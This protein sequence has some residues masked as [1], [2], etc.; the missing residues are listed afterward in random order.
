MYSMLKI[1]LFGAADVCIELHTADVT[2]T[3]VSIAH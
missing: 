2:Y 1:Q 3:T